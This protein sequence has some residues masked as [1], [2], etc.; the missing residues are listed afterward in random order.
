MSVCLS[1]YLHFLENSGSVIGDNYFSIGATQSDTHTEQN[2]LR[3]HVG[4]DWFRAVRA[5]L[6]SILSMPF[7]PKDVF[8]RLATVRAAMILIY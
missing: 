6:T 8:M 7:G 2:T 1:T 4:I 5:Y 3:R